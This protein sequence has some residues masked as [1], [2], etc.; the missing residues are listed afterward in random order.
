M[1]TIL[2]RNIRALRKLR[3]L[4]QSQ[5]ARLIGFTQS[6]VSKWEKDRD[7]S[8]PGFDAVQKMADLAGVMAEDFRFVPLDEIGRS[9]SAVPSVDELMS[10]L[11][12]AQREIP[13]ATPLGDWPQEVAAGLHS[14]LVQY[15]RDRKGGSAQPGGGETPHE[16]AVPFRA[17]TRP[18]VLEG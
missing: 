10:M 16:G 11:A 6:S 17:P 9:G 8:E 3:G 13:A 5:F 7:P 18:P 2:S 14:R 4:D 12:A 1:S 15:V